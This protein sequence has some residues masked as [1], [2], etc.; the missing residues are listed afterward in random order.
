MPA[1]A[2]QQTGEPDGIRAEVAAG[3]VADT[4][5]EGK[6]MTMKKIERPHGDLVR[7]E[8]PSNVPVRLH[9]V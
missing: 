5:T 7:S 3:P 2:E 4:G 9:S 8:R 6:I 1:Y